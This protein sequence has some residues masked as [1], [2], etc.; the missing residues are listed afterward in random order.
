MKP[1]LYLGR[2]LCVSLLSSSLVPALPAA[3]PPAVPPILKDVHRILFLGD[4]ITY[5]GDYIDYV[6][7]YLLIRFPTRRWEVLNLGLPSETVSGLSEPGHAGGAFPRPDL[8][9]R[10]DRVL[11]R[12]KPDLVVA[13]YGM[14]DGIYYPFSE[15]R[16]HKFQDGL[17]TLHNKVRA[18]G[19]QIIYLTPPVFDPVPL[20]GRTLPAGLPEYRQPF[21]GY[22]TVLDRYAEW[23]LAQRAAGWVVLDIHGPMNRCLAEHRAQDPAYRLAGDG[24]HPG[25]AGH[26]LM[27]QPLL[28]EWGAPAEFASPADAQAMLAAHPNGKELLKLVQERQRLLKDAWLTETGHQRPGMNKGLPLAQAQEKAAQLGRQINAL[29]MTTPAPTAKRDPEGNVILTCAATNVVIRYTLD[30][31]DPASEAGAYLAPM[32][33]PFGGTVISRAF[34]RDGS[35]RSPVASARFDPLPGAAPRPHSA[36]LPITQNRDWRS[37]DWPARHAAIQALVRARQPEL[38]FIG[39]SITHFFGGEPRAHL[40]RGAEA[41]DRLCCRRNAV[42]LGFGWDRTENVLWR[43]KHGELDGAAPKVVVVLIGTNNLDVNSPDEIADGVRAICAELHA[44]LPQANILL[45]AILPRSAKPDARRVKLGEVNARLGRFDGQDRITFLDLGSKFLGAD[46]SIPPELMDDYLHPTAKGY[47]VLVEAIEPTLAR[48]LGETAAGASA[49]FPGRRSCW[50][51][52]DRFDFDAG[53]RTASVIAPR[54]PRPGRLWA[55]KGEFLDAF[56]GTEI[57]LL[58]QGVYLVYLN[59]PDMLGSPTAVAAWNACYAELTARH[60][61][62]KKAALIGLSRGGLYCYNWAAANPD[63]VACIYGDAPVCDLKSWPGGKGK[64][65]GSPRDWKLVLEQF[66]F[67]SDQEA[68]AAMVSPID[69]LAPL[70]QARLPLLHVYGDADEVVPW[71]ENTGVLARRYR[72]LGGSI[73]LIGKPGIGHHPHGLKDPAPVVNFILTNLV[74]ANAVPPR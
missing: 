35:A 24:V 10:L 44:R 57:A 26:W 25:S 2:L 17:R 42:N 60:G 36:L 1:A 5:G 38:V 11:A 71:D 68:L 9:E 63:K 37:Y 28:L 16:F 72:E 40:A 7:T 22:N 70:A 12:T 58:G 67:R 66:G 69:H 41:W 62:A 50:N 32:A 52:F 53:G 74:S 73:T 48:L 49:P 54:Q 65:P 21:E 59:A 64:G 33:L 20:K 45:L 51:G 13:C 19:A 15:D 4:S 14:N 39:D 61:L 31:S 55:W 18:A 43:L 29:A 23:L 46:G 27:A 8:H 30:G 34:S 56:P 3:D 47:T 6:E